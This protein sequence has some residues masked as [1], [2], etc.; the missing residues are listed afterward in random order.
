[1]PM[2]MPMPMLAR[3]GQKAVPIGRGTYRQS[4][5]TG[6]GASECTRGGC[7]QRFNKNCVV[8]RSPLTR[9]YCS[10][11]LTVSAL[12]CHVNQQA[13]SNSVHQQATSALRIFLSLCRPVSYGRR[14]ERFRQMKSTTDIITMVQ[15]NN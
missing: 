15:Y 2:P 13:V 1:M 7:L 10:L 14:F 9:C 11:L 3:P 6:A 12:R 8:R 4:N 5:C